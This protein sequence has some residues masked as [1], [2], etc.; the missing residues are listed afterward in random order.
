[1]RPGDGGEGG[2]EL[3]ERRPSEPDEAPFETRVAP[4]AA[5]NDECVHGVHQP[6]L[7]LERVGER[8]G[9]LGIEAACEYLLAQRAR[10]ARPAVGPGSDLPS[11]GLP[12][13]AVPYR[14]SYE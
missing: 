14:G 11:R 10:G 6:P 1:M 2:V 12:P 8:E 5:G 13:R 3:G 7:V 9:T 4:Q